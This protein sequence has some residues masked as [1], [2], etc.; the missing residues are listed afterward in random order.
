MPKEGHITFEDLKIEFGY[1]VTPSSLNL[2]TEEE[3][4]FRKEI[5]AIAKREIVPKA[6]EVEKTGDYEII[7]GILGKLGKMGVFR[8]S[9]PKE[10][11]GEGEGAVYRTIVAEEFSAI[12]LAIDI[13]RMASTDLF[14]FPILKFGT[15]EQQEKFLKPLM[16]GK[17]IGAIGITEP[18]G[19]SDAVGGMRTSAVKKGDEYVINGEKRFITNGGVG[20]YV[21]VYAITNPKVDAKNGISAFIVPTKA[22]GFELVKKYELMGRRGAVNSQ[23]RF[24]NC[25]VPKE[26]LLG[27]ENKG[28][29]IMMQGLDAERTCSAAQYL[30]IARSAF[31]I[32]AK[33]AA[34]RM[35]FDKPIRQFEGISFKIAEMASLIEA[36][37]MLVLRAARLIDSE[38]NATKE[39]AMAKFFSADNGFWVCNTALQILGGIGYTKEYPVER[40]LRDIRMA[41][42]GAG[43]S[44]I[45]RYLVQR[46]IYKEMGY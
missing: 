33:F 28:F 19:G 7:R 27:V 39:A 13:S 29:T 17:A 23:L 14:G 35:Q 10:I 24:K 45:L 4:A 12:S 37:R 34:E 8:T 38:K 43:T 30:G 42:I 20:D 9:Y 31:E 46:E 2:Y 41:P 15:K 36:T 16:E 5:R 6:E 3:N 40:Y 11:G 25:T 26:N 21:L 32:A 44:E 18:T 22:D 1:S